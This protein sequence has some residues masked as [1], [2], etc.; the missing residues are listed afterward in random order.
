MPLLG[1][2]LVSAISA[3]PSLYH[4]VMSKETKS[5]PTIVSEVIDDLVWGETRV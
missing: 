1:N 2:I 5:G 3:D 4:G